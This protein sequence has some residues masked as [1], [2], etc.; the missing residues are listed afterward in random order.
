MSTPS[1]SNAPVV[2]PE[3]AEPPTDERPANPAPTTPP[4]PPAANP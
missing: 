4:A 1:S 2:S 3:A